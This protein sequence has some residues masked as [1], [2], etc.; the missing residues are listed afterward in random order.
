MRKLFA[1]VLIVMIWVGFTPSATAAAQNTHLVPCR[2]SPIF[3][4]ADAAS[5]KQLLL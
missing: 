1:L 4:E 2:D 5:S 3:R